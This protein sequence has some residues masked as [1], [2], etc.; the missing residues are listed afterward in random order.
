MFKENAVKRIVTATFQKPDGTPSEGKVRL[1]LDRV[2]LGRQENTVYSKQAIEIEL[3]SSGSFSKELVVT[4]PG[5]TDEEQADL[6]EIANEVQLRIDELT[7]VQERINDYIEKMTNGD[8]I[9]PTDKINYDNDQDRKRE[10]QLEI[11][12]YAQQNKAFE[13]KI[14]ELQKNAAVLTV[15]C[16]FKNPTDQ[17]RIRLIIPAGED[18]IDIADLPRE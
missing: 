11:A 4:N 6:D 13:D 2:V 15:Q 9:T 18:P 12:D 14:R 10:L 8:T 1:Q 16:K 5:L 17:S 3:D 7:T